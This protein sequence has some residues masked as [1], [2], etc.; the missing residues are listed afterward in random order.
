MKNAP[1]QPI[2]FMEDCFLCGQPFQYGPHRYAGRPIGLWQIL[3]CEGCDKMNWNGLVTERHPKLM[4]RL[5]EL[6][7]P[8]ELN[9]KG[10]LPLPRQF[11]RWSTAARDFSKAWTAL[12]PTAT[13]TS[14]RL[15]HE[16]GDGSD[17]RCL[18]PQTARPQAVNQGLQRQH[19]V[20]DAVDARE[21]HIGPML[22]VVGERNAVGLDLGMHPIS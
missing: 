19:P 16:A 15:R 11:R 13:A 8:V 9:A 20:V 3:I 17:A 5:A 10:W 21:Q 14:A 2:K 22:A 12:E 18:I 4:Q 1:N 7:V 6:G